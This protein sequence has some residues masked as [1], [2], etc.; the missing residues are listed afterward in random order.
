M[1]A[2]LVCGRI[3]GAGKC[4]IFSWPNR[5]H[6]DFDY[7]VHMGTGNPYNFDETRS[8]SWSRIFRVCVRNRVFHNQSAG[9]LKFPVNH[10]RPGFAPC[11]A[12]AGRLS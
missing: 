9:Y 5:S 10:L 8:L 2:I 11:T 6:Q 7:R 3:C 1:S 4:F 12:L